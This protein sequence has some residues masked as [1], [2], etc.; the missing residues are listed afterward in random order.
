MYRNRYYGYRK[1]NPIVE[2]VKENTGSCIM[3]IIV[4][5]LLVAWLT[6]DI[7]PK[8]RAKQFF[9]ALGQEPGFTMLLDLN[10]YSETNDRL[11][12]VGAFNQGMSGMLDSAMGLKL[13]KSYNTDTGEIQQYDNVDIYSLDGKLIVSGEY[14][15]YYGST[16]ALD[17]GYHIVS[18]NAPGRRLYEKDYKIDK[19]KVVLSKR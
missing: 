12:L 10:Q 4:V 9:N 5:S 3:G 16:M 8:H 14:L 2:F 17:M 15:G 13:F 18:V 6:T 1:N 11:N 19:N 7:L